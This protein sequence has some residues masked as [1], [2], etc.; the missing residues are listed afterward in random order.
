MGVALTK[1][2][3]LLDPLPGGPRMINAI[4]YVVNWAR[5]NSLGPLVY[6]TSCCAI[7]MMAAGGS[8]HDWSRFGVEVAR[9]S[10]RQADLIILSVDDYRHLGYR[11]GGNLVQTVL[12][13]GQV[14]TWPA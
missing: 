9:A 13:R 8:H 7:E 6:G 11:F 5:A 12:K 10:P 1:L 14:F 3:P 2:P 4:D